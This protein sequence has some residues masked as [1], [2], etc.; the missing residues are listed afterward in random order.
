MYPEIVRF[1]SFLRRKNPH[2]STHIHYTSDIN[3]FFKFIQKRPAAI[4]LTDIDA[5]IEHCHQKGFAFSTINRRLAAIRSF[6]N[7]LSLES[8]EAPENPVLP[9]RHFLPLGQHLPRDIADDDLRLFFKHVN[10]PR[11]MAIF[12]LMLRCGLRVGEIRNLSL[13]DLFL[14]PMP[15][16][17]PRIWLIGKGSAQRVAYLSNQPISALHH[18]L[19]IRP[20]VESTA[21]FTNRFGKRMTVTGIQDRLAK[22][23][24]LAGVWITCHQFRHTFGRHLVETRIPVTSIQKLLGHARLRTTELY[25]K[26]SD[27]Q[28]QEDYEIAMREVSRRLALEGALS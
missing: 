24:R 14:H 26:I 25:L 12:L 27:K 6:F 23:C 15:G 19:V 7:F 22:Y 17:L 3:I 21:V 8:E 10:H 18:W 16:S 11:D 9:K 5:F 2:S 13:N 4:S 20:D 28:I 1:Q